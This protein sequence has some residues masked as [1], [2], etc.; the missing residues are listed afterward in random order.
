L[1]GSEIARSDVEPSL[2]LPI[3]VFGKADAAWLS[4]RFE[5]SGDVDAVA[6]QVA[7]GLLNDVAEVDADPKFDALVEQDLGVALDHRPLDFD[8]A[9]TAS[10]TLRN[11]MMPPSPVRLT[12]RP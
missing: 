11:S 10:T 3:C 6:H 7:V 9:V 4:R 5:T 8:G 1:D 2:N 12:T